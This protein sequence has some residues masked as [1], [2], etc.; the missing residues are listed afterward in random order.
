MSAALRL[1]VATVALAGLAFAGVSPASAAPRSLPATDDM[2]AIACDDAFPNMQLF[3]VDAATA[4]S[5]EIG[6]GDGTVAC[7]G[8]AAWDATTNTAYY[9]MFDFPQSILATIDTTTGST[10]TVGYFTDTTAEPDET[11][12]VQAIAIGLDGAAYA[13]SDDDFYSLDLATGT[14]TPLGAV[15]TEILGFSVDPTTGLFYAVD[16]DGNVYSVNVT[17]GTLL[18]VDSVSFGAGFEVYSLQIDSAGTFW[19]ASWDGEVETL[20]LWS[21]GPDIAGTEELSGDFVLD[22][23]GYFHESLLVTRSPAPAE[24][25]LANT[26]ADSSSALLIG[27][28]ALGALTLGVVMFVARRRAARA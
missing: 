14:V 6:T 26:G 1:T 17:D 2:Y 12:F 8:Q 21:T 11:P 18:L 4:V 15:A 16:A 20:Q 5:A 28:G 10:T 22:G 9:V 25:A 24:P 7:A 19:Y 23:V 3:S 13:F 27:A